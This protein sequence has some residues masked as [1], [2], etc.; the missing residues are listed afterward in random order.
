METY[1]G[2]GL[3]CILGREVTRNKV[4]DEDQDE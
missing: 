1:E 3:W 2:D 4:S